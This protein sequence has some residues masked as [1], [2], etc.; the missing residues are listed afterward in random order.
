MT[1]QNDKYLRFK[2]VCNRYRLKEKDMRFLWKNVKTIFCHEE[3]QKRMQ[4]P[5]WHHQDVTIGEHILGDTILAYKVCKSKNKDDNFIRRTLYISMF[6]DL[7]VQS[8]MIY[9]KKEYFINSHAFSHPIEAIINAITWFPQCFADLEDAKIIIDGV[10]HHM[11]PCPVRAFTSLKWEIFNAA[12]YEK[13][14]DKYKTI[15]T[16]SLAPCLFK[17]MALRKSFYL[18]GRILSH[19]DKVITMKKD[20][21]GKKVFGACKTLLFA[22]AGRNKVS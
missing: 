20:L 18:E 5:F 14:D 13:L 22:V 8:W 11:Y 15:I 12:L 9:H 6:H 3:F 17:N 10:L 21:R 4:D 1:K 16:C 2:E 7:Y 19:V